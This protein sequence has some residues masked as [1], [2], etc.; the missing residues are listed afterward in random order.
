MLD[1]KNIK[2]Q[3]LWENF[4]G[5]FRGCGWVDGC[6]DSGLGEDKNMFQT[7]VP[8]VTRQVYN[9]FQDLWNK[10]LDLFQKLYHREVK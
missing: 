1:Y 6:V 4:W 7:Y 2:K 9:V 3:G 8:Q 5:S 10:F